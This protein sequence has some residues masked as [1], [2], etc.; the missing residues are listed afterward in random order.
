MRVSDLMTREVITVGRGDPLAHAVELML[1]AGAGSA[2]VTS[3][4]E[5]PVGI[6]TSSDVLRATL[7]SGATLADLSVDD[8]VS[9]PLVTIEPGAPVT[10]ALD[11]MAEHGIK[12]LPVLEALSLVGIVTTTDVARELPDY[13]STI[14]NIEAKGSRKRE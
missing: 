6:V 14:R 7:E 11:T 12:K 13:V 5:A 4:A 9:E 1:A 2:V 3:D 8:A 10:R